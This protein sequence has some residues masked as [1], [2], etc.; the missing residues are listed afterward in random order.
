[1]HLRICRRWRL[2]AA[3]GRAAIFQYYHDRSS[4]NKGDKARIRDTTNEPAIWLGA[5]RVYRPPDT[6]GFRR[7]MMH[8]ACYLGGPFIC[9]KVPPTSIYFFVSLILSSQPSA[10]TM[11][12]VYFMYFQAAFMESLFV[13]SLDFI[14]KIVNETIWSLLITS[15]NAPH[16]DKIE[17]LSRVSST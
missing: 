2:H 11:L 3:R 1:M 17:S 6:K 12:Y 9:S 15:N 16:D 14:N 10:S 8:A 4:G 7:M 5:S 13:E